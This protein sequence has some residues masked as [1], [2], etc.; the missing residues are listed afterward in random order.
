M[1]RQG[2]ADPEIDIIDDMVMLNIIISYSFFEHES[3]PTVLE[4]RK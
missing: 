2:R 1:F 4:N 3:T